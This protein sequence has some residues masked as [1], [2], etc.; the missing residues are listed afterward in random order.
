MSTTIQRNWKFKLGI[1]FFL[2][3][4]LF[5]IAHASEHGPDTHEHNGVVCLAILSDEQDALVPSADQIKLFFVAS[6]SR[7]TD[8]IRQAPLKHLRA[9]RPPPTGPPL[10]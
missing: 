9:I 4:Q 2:V 10:I 7:A 8:T 1:L 6:G 3:G 5:S